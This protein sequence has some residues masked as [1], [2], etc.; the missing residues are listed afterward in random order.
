[1]ISLKTPTQLAADLAY[2]L[3]ARR[4]EKAWTQAEMAERAGLKLATYV[5]FE[6]TGQIS[7][8]RLIKV[9]EVLGLAGPIELIADAEDY[10]QKT[11]SD[12][13]QPT[14]QRGRRRSAS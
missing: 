10:S 13:L 9:L 8:L 7:L 11:I 3:K 6:R 1:M 4:L 14:R 5:L 2:R 12:I